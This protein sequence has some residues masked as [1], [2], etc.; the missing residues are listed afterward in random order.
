M[1]VQP[2]FPELMPQSSW[3]PPD[4]FP[5]ISDARWWS[6]DIETK[7]PDLRSRGPGF[8]RGSAFVCGFAI[9]VEGYCK[10]FPVRHLQGQNLAP[11][12]AFA[13]LRDQA[14]NFHGELYGANILYEL[15]GL[16]YEGVEFN[17]DVRYH[18]VQILEPIID[19]ETS[20]GFSLGVLSN[21]WLGESKRETVLRE[22]A[23]RYTKGYRGRK[24]ISFDP[25][26]D[27]WALPP[28]YVGEY[29]EGDVLLPR[30]IYEKQIKVIDEEGLRPILDLESSLVP[31]LLKMR[32]QGVRV[33][34][35]AAEKLQGVLTRE[36]D[37]YS[38]RIKQLVGFNPNVDSGQEM[39][40]AYQ[41]L[42]NMM[43][44]KRI[45]ES[46]RY[47]APTKAFPQGQAS[48]TA[49]WMSLQTDLLSRAVLRKKKLMTLRDD[50]VVGDILN[51]N[52]GGRI[53]A[54]FHSLRQDENGTRDGRFS[55]TNPNLQQIP[56]RHD[57]CDEDCSAEC[58]THVWGASDSNWSEEVRKLFVPDDGKRWL[59]ADYSQQEPR[60]LIHF[61]SLC[62][63][64]GAREAVEAFR[65]DPRTDYHAFTTKLVNER[66]GKN[67]KRKRIKAINLA[68]FYGVGVVKLA[69]LL[70]LSIPEAQDVLSDY[71][72]ALPF[73][74]ALSNKAMKVA[75][76]RGFVR[77]ILGRKCR[78]NTWEPVPES[79][80][81]RQF[82]F[83]G[84]P[85]EQAEARWPGRRL[86]RA[87]IH[88]A[89]NKICQ[90]SAADQTKK[91]MHDL[92]YFHGLVPHIQVHDELAGSVADL[93]EA[94]TYKKTMETCILLEIPVIAETMIG[95]SWGSAKEEI[96]L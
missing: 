78:F 79:K 35:E 85:R 5:E 90:P 57:A 26:S 47:T 70:N 9:H 3:V 49:D 14:K 4:S 34:L 56:N 63:L 29:C 13:W 8:R 40:K 32:L 42:Q 50:F 74:R 19:S 7:D 96:F 24:P 6:L 16:Y 18:D 20:K 15:E 76:E 81:E 82:K 38:A 59:R 2:C 10:Y 60:L 68:G 62:N 83:A 64:P 31:I 46:I 55:S 71:H 43:P 11:N 51:E 65:S 86:Q 58:T 44:D 33:D 75:E 54:R 93:G 80:E 94:R 12:V 91:A 21:K 92:Y 77:T 72:R 84:L 66:C 23:E 67:F 28:E 73:V 27:I 89:L 30:M 22:A 36:I 88:K 87:G 1:L 69:R 48:F 53:Y 17:D 95:D 37:K 41:V 45:I 39:Y 25:K 61:A 52:V